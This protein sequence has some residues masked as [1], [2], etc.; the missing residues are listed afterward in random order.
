MM[1]FAKLLVLMLAAVVFWFLGLAIHAMI[2]GNM[3][4]IVIYVALS[5]FV[6]LLMK[7]VVA[8]FGG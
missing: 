7:M 5:G 6:L 1:G 4:M 3:N 2:F 8:M